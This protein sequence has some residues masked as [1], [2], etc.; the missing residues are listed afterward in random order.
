MSLAKSEM[1][2]KN[3]NAFYVIIR[4]FFKKGKLL[5]ILLSGVF[6]KIKTQFKSNLKLCIYHVKLPDQV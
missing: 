2:I 3:K 1:P 4:S 5:F 6:K